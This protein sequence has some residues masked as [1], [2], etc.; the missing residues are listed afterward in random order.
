VSTDDRFAYDFDGYAGSVRPIQIWSYRGGRFLDVS[1][2]HPRAIR[3]D[4]ATLWRLYVKYRGKQ[5]VRGILPAWAADQYL[6]DRGAT[7]Q[8]ALD[9]ARRR[10]DLNC[11]KFCFDGPRDAAAYVRAVNR[12]LHKYGYLRT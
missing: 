4:A 9:E 7:A 5:G 10:G 1:R 2:H 6:L 8:R 11:P 3:R 12:L